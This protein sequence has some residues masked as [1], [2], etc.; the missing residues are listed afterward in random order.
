MR[1]QI[2]AFVALMAAAAPAAAQSPRWS[3]AFN[4]G[5]DVPL[6]GNVHDGGSGRVLTLPT[7]VQARDYGD[8]Y[9]S[10]FTW[11]ADVGFL[12]GAG[13]EVR[14]RVFRTNGDAA[15]VQVGDVATL[16]LFAQFD[17]YTATG[18]DAGYRQ[19][20]TGSDSKVRPY[21][22]ASVGFLRTD[23]INAT[24]SVPAA[25]VVLKDVPMY[26][27]SMVPTFAVSAGAMV[28]L[29]RHFGVQGGIDLRW[30]G[31]LSPV[32]GLAGTGLEAINDKSRRWSLPVTVGAVVRF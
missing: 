3:V 20:L 17:P 23:T 8:I 28:P 13:S 2:L 14:A 22:G 19:Y 26:E 11:S 27:A 32:D 5:T 15:R 6:S 25:N 10:L 30:H 1:K 12:M 7:T 29:G 16:A 24:F 9:G 4:L 18:M 21:A 31:N